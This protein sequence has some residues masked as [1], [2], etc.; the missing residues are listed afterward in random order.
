MSKKRVK[1]S[2][3]IK[4]AIERSGLTRYRISKLSG[5]SAAVLSR[6]VNGKTGLNLSNLD[7]LADVIGIRVAMTKDTDTTKKGQ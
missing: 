7:R 6:F 4:D 2:E 5:I 1:F 3:Q